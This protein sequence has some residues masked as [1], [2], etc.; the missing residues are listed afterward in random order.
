MANICHQPIITAR[1]NHFDYET[2][3]ANGKT[4][5][6]LPLQQTMWSCCVHSFFFPLPRLVGVVVMDDLFSTRRCCPS[7][8]N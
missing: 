2:P 1:M 7:R 3:A 8:T 4:D 6:L 5:L